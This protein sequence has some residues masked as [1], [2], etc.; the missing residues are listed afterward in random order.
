MLDLTRAHIQALDIYPAFARH[1]FRHQTPFRETGIE[2]PFVAMAK[3]PRN[4]P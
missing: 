1:G 2:I 4:F 3:D